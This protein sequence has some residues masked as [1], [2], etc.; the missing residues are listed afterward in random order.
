M[1]EE[2]ARRLAKRERR[3]QRRR[4]ARQRVRRTRLRRAAIL[5]GLLAVPALWGV[6]RS[7][8]QALVD[9]EVIETRLWRHTAEDGT[10]HVHTAATLRI[11]GLAEADL[12]RAEGYERGQRVPVWIRRGRMS[13]WP[14][15]L[16]VAK[17]GEIERQKDED[18]QGLP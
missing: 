9:A 17:P 14:Y 8:P 5:A 3:E 11:E 2:E 6:E 7:G 1:A 12:S 13:S 18:A 16:D 10:S 4:E 15:F